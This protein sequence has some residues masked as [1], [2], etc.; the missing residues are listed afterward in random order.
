M[1][2]KKPRRSSEAKAKE[3][4]DRLVQRYKRITGK[5]RVHGRVIGCPEDQ[6]CLNPKHYTVERRVL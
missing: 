3:K 5:Q 2:M 1:S 4:A 6:D